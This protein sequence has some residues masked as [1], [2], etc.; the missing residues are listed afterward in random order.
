MPSD[1]T[2]QAKFLRRGCLVVL[3]A[4]AMAGGDGWTVSRTIFNHLAPDH[5]GATL[6]GVETAL[7]YL[8][9]KAYA[10]V[11]S[12]QESKFYGAVLGSMQAKI[13]PHGTDLLEETIPP[14]PGVEDNR[15]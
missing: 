12:R 10:S 11:R 13:L 1:D 4:A 15:E 8:G 5:P 3:R 6:S 2:V 14:D 9:E 7:R